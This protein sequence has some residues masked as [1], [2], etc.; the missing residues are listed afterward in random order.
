MGNHRTTRTGAS[1]TGRDRRWRSRVV[2]F[3]GRVK[4][5]R[6]HT[7]QSGTE[8]DEEKDPHS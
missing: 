8:D 7:T 4:L 5:N 1:G 2:K 3:G 6:L